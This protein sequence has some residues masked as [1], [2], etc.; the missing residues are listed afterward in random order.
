MM[1]RATWGPCR[2]S[3]KI[4]PSYRMRKLDRQIVKKIVAKMSEVSQLE[5]PRSM[6]KRLTENKSGL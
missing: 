1:A 2:I 3:R 5:D 4:C 6:G